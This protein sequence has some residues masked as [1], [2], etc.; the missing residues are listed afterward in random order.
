[1]IREDALH[2]LLGFEGSG[3][4]V[5]SLYLNVDPSQ[6]SKAECRLRV[7]QLLDPKRAEAVTEDVKRVEEFLGHEY[8][9]Q[10]KGLVIF[11]CAPKNFWHVVRLQVPVVDSATVSTKPY[12]RQLSETLSDVERIGVALVDRQTARYFGIYMDAIQELAT[13][14]RDMLRRHKQQGPSPKLQR[15]ADENAQQ[16]IKQAAK[17]AGAR[18]KEFG[19]NRVV[20]A[21]QSEQV[22]AFKEYLPKAWQE[23]IIGELP[24]DTEATPAQVLSRVNQVIAKV[25][26]EQ[27]A[28][29][30]KSVASAAQKKGP[31]GALGLQDT[32]AAL[33]DGRVMTFVAASGFT[34]TG[35]Q[36]ENCGYL[37]ATAL[38]ACPA[39]G[40]KMHGVDHLV[41]VAIR[42]ALEN[43]A[44]VESIRAPEPAQR[45]RELGGVGA[46]LRY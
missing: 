25:D 37:S 20:L 36:C 26:A 6:R 11:S 19:A 18:F 2:T 1:M 22:T 27:Q 45:L 7:K 34:A 44:H 28:E 14:Q 42:K 3:A 10:A 41:D 30:V 31:T 32:L 15:A 21:G 39:C 35:Y 5:L 4:P 43:N 23:C 46:L 13:T 33:M 16:N 29:L 9:W 12:L 8:D 40:H 38:D 17:D 24:L